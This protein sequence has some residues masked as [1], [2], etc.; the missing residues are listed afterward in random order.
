M[1]SRPSALA[2]VSA[3]VYLFLYAPILVLVAFSFNAGR[4]TAEWTGFTFD[5]YARAASNPQILVALRNSLK[6]AFTATVV[7]TKI[8]RAHV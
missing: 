7:A 5:W 6:V 2:A 3:A 1:R 4:L 8:G